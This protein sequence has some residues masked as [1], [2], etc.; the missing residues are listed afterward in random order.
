MIKKGWGKLGF[1]DIYSMGSGQ[2]LGSLGTLA[3]G[4]LVWSVAGDEVWGGGGGD[5]AANYSGNYKTLVKKNKDGC[6]DAS[7]YL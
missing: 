5:T 1:S 4:A 2:L 7:V 3:G 6:S